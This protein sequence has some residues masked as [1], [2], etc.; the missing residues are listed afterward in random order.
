MLYILPQYPNCL[1]DMKAVFLYAL[2]WLSFGAGHTV[3]TMPSVKQRFE[4]MLGGGYRLSYNL[5]AVVHLG[6][7]LLI[8]RVLLSSNRFDLLNSWP[9]SLLSMMLVVLGILLMLLALRQY[10]L[11]QFSGL[12]QMRTAK[13]DRSV[14]L[15]PLSV[16]GMNR[17]VRHPLYSGLFLFLWGGALSPLGFWTAVFASV[18]VIIGAY[19]EE[20]KLLIVYG[21]AYAE[22][23]SR[24]PAFFPR[25]E[26]H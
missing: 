26:S 18:Y 13:S 10:D 23:K 4:P 17:W 7:V 22:Y 19:Y 25:R 2:L 21:D 15:E 3:L 11:G 6:V 20:Q 1:N 5:L 8:G 12:A 14:N 24:V 16:S 9:F